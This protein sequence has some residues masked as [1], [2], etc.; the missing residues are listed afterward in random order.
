MA[1]V[2]VVNVVAVRPLQQLLTGGIAGGAGCC[3]TTLESHD[4]RGFA[5]H[6]VGVMRAE[7]DRD[8]IS[9]D[10]PQESIEL[11]LCLGVDASGWLIEEQDARRRQESSRDER[12]LPLATRELGEQSMTQGL[13]AQASEELAELRSSSN[14]WP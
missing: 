9:M 2:N 7:D 6:H 3:D 5:N 14:G 4:V 13:E 12:S 8:A 1:M 10:G 11:L